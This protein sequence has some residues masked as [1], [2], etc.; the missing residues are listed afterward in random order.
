MK[1]ECSSECKPLTE[2]VDFIV[3]LRSAFENPMQEVCHTLDT[4]GDGCPNQ[5]YT[6]V[7]ADSTV[8]PWFVP[9]MVDVT[10]S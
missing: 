2:T 6:K 10:V 9:M 1:W 5:H 8:D 3:S 4:R 7:V